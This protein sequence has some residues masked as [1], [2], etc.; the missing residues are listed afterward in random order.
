M[1]V[2]LGSDE[3]ASVPKSAPSDVF[4]NN[5]DYSDVYIYI[6][7]KDSKQAGHCDGKSALSE[8][9]ARALVRYVLKKYSGCIQ[10]RVKG[11]ERILY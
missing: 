3:G 4:Q 9:D 11:I 6:R 8:C 2:L 5:S 1:E 7:G 10:S